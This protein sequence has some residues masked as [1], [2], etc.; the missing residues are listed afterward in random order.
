MG[1]TP[2]SALLESVSLTLGWTGTLADGRI[3][4]ATNWN[5]GYNRR[6]QSG[7]FASRPAFG[8]AGSNYY[9]TDTGAE[10][11]DN[12]SAWALKMPAFSGDVSSSANS[13][14]LTL[15]TVNG[16][17]GS[18]GSASNV[19]SFTV[20][21]KGLITAASNVAIALAASQIT[22]GSL[23]ANVGGSGFSSYT[24][25]DILQANTTSTLAKLAAV[26]TG[27]VLIS[28]G[29]GTVSSWGKVGFSTHIS[30]LTISSPTNNDF[31]RYNGSAWVN[32]AIATV[33]STVNYWAKSSNDLTYSGGDVQCLV[34]SKAQAK[35]IGWSSH[36]ATATSGS[37]GEILIGGTTSYQAKI[38]YDGVNNANVR[39]TNTY[40]SA[41]LAD[42]GFD[43]YCYTSQVLRVHVNSITAYKP[44][45]FP[46]YTV[47]GLPTG[48]TY[49]RAFVS[50]ASSPTFGST[51]AGGGAVKTPV[52]YDGTNWKVG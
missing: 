39:F 18:F 16:N 35:F 41:T 12:G 30:G 46:V 22:S 21:G 32:T 28:G 8:T 44:V 11:Y 40:N 2:A 29:V 15:A 20:N 36:A 50:D 45:I 38:S 49:M 3:A 14:A 33:Q 17:V 25:G 26:A 51:V 10:Y 19:A 4:S 31:L 6:I 7:V 52:W 48:T 1:G 5:T 47:A 34:N 24:V 42:A 23:A 37:N 13:L 43:F 27:N 9:A